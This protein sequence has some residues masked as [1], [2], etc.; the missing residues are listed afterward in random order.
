LYEKL[1][2]V[3][4]FFLCVCVFVVLFLKELR[5]TWLCMLLPCSGVYQRCFEHPQYTAWMW[6]V[7]ALNHLVVVQ[8]V[9]YTRSHA[10]PGSVYSCASTLRRRKLKCLY[11]YDLNEQQCMRAQLHGASLSHEAVSIAIF[12]APA[13]AL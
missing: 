6:S 10:L 8:T 12:R 13:R 11:L 7:R 2:N 9:Q 3:F 5:R 1:A 4:F